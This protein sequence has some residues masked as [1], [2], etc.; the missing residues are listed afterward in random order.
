MDSNLE[1]H[2][3][4]DFLETELSYPITADEVAT[5]IGEIKIAAPNEDGS[6]SIGE[7]LDDVGQDEYQSADELD[8]MIHT[9][10]P[11]E[12]VGRKFYDDRGGQQDDPRTGSEEDQSF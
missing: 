5:Q 2:D 11:D 10:L 7:L 1:P 12:Y 9:M 8:Q 6:K 4:R 3:V